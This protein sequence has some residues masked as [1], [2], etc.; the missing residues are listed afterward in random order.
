MKLLE[1]KIGHDKVVAII[2]EIA[3]QEI[4]FDEYPHSAEFMLKVR[5]RINEEIEKVI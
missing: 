5:E 3:G 2:E 1:G 4:T